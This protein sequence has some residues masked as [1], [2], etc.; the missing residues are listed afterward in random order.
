MAKNYPPDGFAVTG[1][2]TAWGTDIDHDGTVLITG[3]ASIV[4]EDTVPSADPYLFDT[5][6][7]PCTA[8]DLFR[9]DAWVRADDKTAGNLVKFYL[10]WYTTAKVYI[11]TGQFLANVVNTINTWERKSAILEAPATAGY[12][13]VA[14]GKDNTAA[15]NNYHV[16]FGMAEVRRV[17]YAF[18]AYQGTAQQTIAN[19]TLTKV[20]FPDEVFDYGGVYDNTVNYRFTAPVSGLYLIDGAVK[21]DDAAG[22]T[23]GLVTTA[24]VYKNGVN[25]RILDKDYTVAGGRNRAL[26]NSVPMELAAND[27]I[28]IYA[29]HLEGANVKTVVSADTSFAVF[30]IN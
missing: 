5:E 30:H 3:N 12:F 11:S 20:Q 29:Y 16:W 1:G 26:I 17:N 28:E 13:R 19:N 2:D 18:Q 6:Y 7:Y 23:G 24:Y 21:L 22:F 4:F 9:G 14:I 15:P 10:H 8:G 25:T 27:Y